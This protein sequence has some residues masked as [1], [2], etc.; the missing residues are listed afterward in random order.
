MSSN[1]HN[2]PESTATGRKTCN[3]RKTSVK[4]LLLIGIVASLI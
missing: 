4:L 2:I 3:V 1:L